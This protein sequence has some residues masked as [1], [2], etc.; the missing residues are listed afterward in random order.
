[1]VDKIQSA[2]VGMW[3]YQSEGGEFRCWGERAGLGCDLK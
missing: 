1:M 2:V 3:K